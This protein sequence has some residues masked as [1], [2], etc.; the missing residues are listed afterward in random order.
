MKT[1]FYAPVRG[2]SPLKIRNDKNGIVCITIKKQDPHP[3]VFTLKNSEATD[4]RLPE[5]IRQVSGQEKSC[6]IVDMTHCVP[7]TKKLRDHLGGQ[8][9]EVVKA[10]AVVSESV[11][12]KLVA[13]IFF[14]LK[15]QPY[16]HKIF[17]NEAEAKK[18]LSGYVLQ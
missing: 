15:P 16:P 7:L 18:W 2:T 6:V 8:L 12:G 4:C 13:E 3:G 14:T 11:Y 9:P 17:E 5:I 1:A 10:A